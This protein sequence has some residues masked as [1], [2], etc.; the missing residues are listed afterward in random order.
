MPGHSKK[1]QEVKLVW[2]GA[3]KNGY[4]SAG[5]NLD[6]GGRLPEGLKAGGSHYFT[7]SALASRRMA[8]FI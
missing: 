3:S 4:G 2:A 7:G 5:S 8:T 1:G 6:T